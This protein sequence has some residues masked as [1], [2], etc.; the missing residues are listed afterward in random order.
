MLD[1][2]LVVCNAKGG[3][4]KSSISAGI[5]ANAAATGHRT[6]LVDLD[7]G[8]SIDQDLGYR[9]SGDSDEG[10]TLYRSVV[11]TDPIEPLRDVR[12]G[13]DVVPAGDFTRA[14]LALVLAGEVP[15]TR[16]AERLEELGRYYELVLI[17]TPPATTVALDVALCAAHFLMMPVGADTGSLDGLELVSERYQVIRGRGLN[18]DLELLGVVLFG[19]DPGQP[20][21]YREVRADVE[22]ELAGAAPVL[23]SFVR[24]RP[25]AA[26]DMRRH[27]L[28]ASEYLRAA[29]ESRGDPT[30][31]T[32]ADSFDA[33]AEGLAQDYWDLT[34]E[35]LESID[36]RTSRMALAGACVG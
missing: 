6:L 30:S 15:P 17:D 25:R 36:R 18:A 20:R 12:T 33:D 32:G 31:L 7:P 1:R 14:A 22:W 27:G 35:V 34:S 13:L 26:R 23:D 24:H 19:M 29:R 16:I 3:V 10:R 2:G 21:L 11:D 28:V 4:G 8:G 9:Q 5:A